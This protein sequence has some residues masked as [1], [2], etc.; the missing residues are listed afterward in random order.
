MYT[1]FFEKNPK[2]HGFSAFQPYIFCRDKMAFSPLSA[3][4]F[5]VF[6][7]AILIV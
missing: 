2:T 6:Y 7:C 4:V 3:R 5:A 1:P